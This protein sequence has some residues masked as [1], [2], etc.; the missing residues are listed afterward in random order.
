ML[1]RNHANTNIRTVQR[2]KCAK[3][4]CF[5]K[6]SNAALMLANRG[7]RA[8]LLTQKPSHDATMRREGGVP[9]QAKILSEAQAREQCMLGGEATKPG[10]MFTVR[11]DTSDRVQGNSSSID[12]VQIELLLLTSQLFEKTICWGF[13]LLVFFK[14]RA[15]YKSQY[16]H[17]KNL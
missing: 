1:Y 13:F 8:R 7:K 14:S 3:T 16:L 10:S 4:F 2:M 15:A 6:H 9:R 11:P 5:L 12:S 17:S